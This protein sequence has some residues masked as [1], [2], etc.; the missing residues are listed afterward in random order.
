MPGRSSK[1]KSK[2][3]PV[4]ETPRFPL[5]VGQMY[6]FPDGRRKYQYREV[7]FDIDGWALASRYLPADY[8]MMYMRCDDERT[9]PGWCNGTKWL[10]MRL[11]DQKVIA[12]KRK[13]EEVDEPKVWGGMN[14]FESTP[15]KNAKTRTAKVRTT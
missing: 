3:K 7:P 10:G 4:D 9:I 1:P 15:R 6:L 12:W 5:K 14:A 8:D 11:R 13:P 2:R